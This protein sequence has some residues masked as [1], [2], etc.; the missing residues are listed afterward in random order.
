MPCTSIRMQDGTA[1]IVCSRGR[2]AHRCEWCGHASL[3]QCDAPLPASS[4]TCSAHM[5][6]AH[7]TH[8][9]NDHELCPRHSE[10]APRQEAL[11]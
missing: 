4:K 7:A 9:G 5:C 10:G 6:E 3:Y 1:A 8:V 11:L 2:R